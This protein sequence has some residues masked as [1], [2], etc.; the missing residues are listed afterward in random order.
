[1]LTSQPYLDQPVAHTRLVVRLVVCRRP[2]LRSSVFEP[3]LRLMPWTDNTAVLDLPLGKRSTQVRAAL[4]QGMHRVSIA[5]KHQILA[6][7]SYMCR[8]VLL[9]VDQRHDGLER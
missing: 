3:E 1:M 6:A 4:G 9:Q 5:D 2:G 7:C 8:P